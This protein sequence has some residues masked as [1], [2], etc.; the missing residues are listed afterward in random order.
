MEN[1]S[2]SQYETPIDG[3]ILQDYKAVNKKFMANVFLWMFLALG[4]SATAAFLTLSVPTIFNAIVGSGMLRIL[5]FVPLVFVLIMSFAFKRLSVAGLIAFFILYS[6]ANGVVF[7]FILLVYTSGSVISCFAGAAVMF[8]VMAIA[9]YKTEQDLTTFGRLL[10]MALIGMIVVSII[11]F[12]MNS[13]AI[14]YIIGLIGIMVFTGLTAYDVQKL[15]N[16]SRGIDAEGNE[17]EH[18]DMKK[19]TVMGALTLYLDFINLFLS[20]LRVFGRKN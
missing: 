6:I 15:K 5:F 1:T 4:V 14:D 9:G 11:N 17:I 2:V 18:A 20:L 12:F 10:F 19:L 16:I 13:E 3:Q 8:G 7:S